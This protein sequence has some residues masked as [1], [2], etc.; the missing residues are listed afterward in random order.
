MVTSDEVQQVV[1]AAGAIVLVASIITAVTPT[2]KD[3]HWLS[4][5]RQVLD[6]LAV[7]LGH[8]KNKGNDDGRD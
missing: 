1:N 2:P 7:N 5:V 6:V 3:D 8:A 4:I